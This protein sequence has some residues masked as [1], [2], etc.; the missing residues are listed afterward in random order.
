MIKKKLLCACYRNGTLQ[1]FLS[2]Q[3]SAS[4][5]L[6]PA[7]LTSDLGAKPAGTR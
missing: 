4:T 6:F 2:N 7:L 1:F 5:C 3:R